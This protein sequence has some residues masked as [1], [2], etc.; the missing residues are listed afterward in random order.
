MPENQS[1]P[2]TGG[3]HNPQGGPQ[4]G[5]QP[6]AERGSFDRSSDTEAAHQPNEGPAIRGDDAAGGPRD[7]L[8]TNDFQGGRLTRDDV[9]ERANQAGREVNL[10]NAGLTSGLDPHAPMG[11]DVHTAGARAA[12]ALP[13]E[14]VMTPASELTRAQGGTR[15]D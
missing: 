15:E 11:T 13:D 6:P 2:R 1:Q 3:L 9:V 4:V 7:Q 8:A 10:G 12:D 14:V 5:D